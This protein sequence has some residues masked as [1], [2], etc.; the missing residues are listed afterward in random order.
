[1]CYDCT[2]FDIFTNFPY[3]VD[4]S[5]NTILNFPYTIGIIYEVLIESQCPLIGVTQFFIFKHLSSITISMATY[6]HKKYL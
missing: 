1:M 3:T 6:I 5:L 2:L 4:D